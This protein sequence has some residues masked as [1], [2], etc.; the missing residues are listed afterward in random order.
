MQVLLHPPLSIL[1]RIVDAC[2]G[3]SLSSVYCGELEYHVF[4]FVGG[5]WEF[6]V[7]FEVELPIRFFVP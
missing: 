1:S 7:M 2:S 6:L 5:G 4:I 3:K